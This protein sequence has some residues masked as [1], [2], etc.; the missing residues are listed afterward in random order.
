MIGFLFGRLF[1]LDML[2]IG[3]LLTAKFPRR[4]GFFWRAPAAV[5]GCLLASV[6]WTALF[7]TESGTVIPLRMLLATFN[8][9]GA[10]FL[11]LGAL[12]FCTQIEGWTYVP[13]KNSPAGST[14]WAWWQLG[15]AW[16]CSSPTAITSGPILGAT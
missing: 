1:F 4:E 2:L 10:F 6:A 8:Y 14:C 7:K 11:V 12:A 3:F 15:S 13:T 5:V 9:L 16:A